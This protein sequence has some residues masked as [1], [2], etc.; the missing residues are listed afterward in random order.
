MN[1][2]YPYENLSDEDFENLIIRIVK[3]VLGIGCKTFS[4]GKDGAKDSWF[5]GKA[6][7]FPSK[8]APWIGTF[9]IQAKHTRV[10]NASCSDN[11]FS[12]NITSV[13]SKEIERLKI[14]MKTTPFDNYILF[15][16]RKLSGVSHSAIVKKLKEGLRIE[17]VEIIGRED[18]D[19][20]LTDYPHIADRFGLYKFQAPLRFYEKE[21]RDVIV[22]F[23]EQSKTISTELKSYITSFTVIN[24]EKKNELNN[25]SKEYFEFLKNHSLQYFDGIEKFLRDPK[26]E[27]YMKM[28]SNTVSDLQEAIIVERNRFNEFEHIIKH[29]IE[30]VVGNNEGK[31]K[32]L[33]KIVRVFIH[34]MYFNCDIGKTA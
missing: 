7:H 6:D 20:Y 27:D 22:V 10:Y 11:D 18:I 4:V 25:L 30:Y 15:T 28:Y 24:K 13:L 14:V 33:R 9:N 21:L 8:G 5:T 16:N 3:E 1:Q 34:F 23:S 17:N 2:Q 26:N 31:L 19:S 29:L 32:D 12:V